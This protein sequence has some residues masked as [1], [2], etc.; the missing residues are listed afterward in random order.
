MSSENIDKATQTQITNI[1]KN[2]GKKLDQWVAIVNKSG[3]TKHGELVSF[4][5]DKH[6][7]THRN[8]NTIVHFAK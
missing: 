1:E 4:L 7:Y 5:K 2:T 6:A 3:F 8:S